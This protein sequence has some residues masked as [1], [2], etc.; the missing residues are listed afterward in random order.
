MNT[1]GTK[2]VCYDY[3]AYEGRTWKYYETYLR[4]FRNGPLRILDIGSGP[5]LFLECCREYGIE[6]CG[7]EANPRAVE[8]CRSRGLK[9][10]QH[11]IGL[12]FVFFKNDSFDAVMCYQVIEH[13]S[14]PA[15]LNV[16][17][18]AYR[19]LRGGGE[20]MVD[21]PCKHFY[22]AT[23]SS[24]HIGLLAPKELASLASAAGFT[25]INMGY[26]YPQYPDD[27]PK[28]VVDELWNAHH[29]DLLS[30]TAAILAVKPSAV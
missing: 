21:S 13:L 11:D 20:I 27:I 5:G 15:Q 7:V 8:E 26:N 28:A 4:R 9:V 25:A 22:P 19:V 2:G 16:L 30:Q 10:F 3:P 14:R 18:E 1:Y 12:P 24:T 6:G 29:P 17:A 23:R